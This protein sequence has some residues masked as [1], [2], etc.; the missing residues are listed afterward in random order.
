[1]HTCAI[2]NR[3]YNESCDNGCGCIRDTDKDRV[4]F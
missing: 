1:M 3:N 2:S 4:F